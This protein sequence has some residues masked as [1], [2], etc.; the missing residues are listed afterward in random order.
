M[1]SRIF[2]H[3]ADDEIENIPLH[4]DI[5]DTDS[6]EDESEDEGSFD[7]ENRDLIPFQI[8]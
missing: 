5:F 4:E 2:V 3:V 7:C 6:E 1:G 8:I